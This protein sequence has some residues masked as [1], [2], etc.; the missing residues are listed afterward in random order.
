M[1]FFHY[2]FDP[3]PDRS[4]IAG[5]QRC[6]AAPAPFHADRGHGRL[7]TGPTSPDP[8]GNSTAGGPADGRSKSTP[9]ARPI[10]GHDPGRASDPFTVGQRMDLGEALARARSRAL[11]AQEPA[12][13]PRISAASP[14][15]DVVK[16]DPSAA[17]PD[18]R[19]RWRAGGDATDGPCCMASAESA[20]AP[21]AR[22]RRGWSRKAGA[23]ARSRH[24]R[25]HWSSWRSVGESSNSHDAHRSTTIKLFDLL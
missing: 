12:D 2:H 10:D 24:G 5:G 23:R 13:A 15:T 4:P 18:C 8:H 16:H 6:V 11:K 22:H 21:P 9:N 17:R 1:A 19:R 14:E 20:Q 25:P 3:T 7:P